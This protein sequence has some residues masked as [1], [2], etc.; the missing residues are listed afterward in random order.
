[1]KLAS[2]RQ[3]WPSYSK[4]L[5]FLGLFLITAGLAI[6]FV[7]GWNLLAGITIA[8]GTIAIA[9]WLF[10]RGNLQSTWALRSTQSNTNALLATLAAL[11]IFGAI[12]FL[13]A[14]YTAKFDLTEK[15]LFTLAPE[16]QQVVKNL[17]QPVKIWIFDRTLSDSD[18]DLLTNYTKINPKFSYQIADPQV[19]FGKAQTFKV[20]SFG[21]VHLE[22]GND[23]RLITTLS[24]ETRLQETDL[25]N[26]IAQLSSTKQSIV[27]F[28]Q[29]HGERP[30]EGEQTGL[31]D[32]IN[33]LKTKNFIAKPLN[34]IREGAIPADA[35]AVA[36]VGPQRS[37][38]D[39]ELSALE[40]YLSQGGR[41][42]ALL[43]PAA[44]GGLGKLLAGWGV[45]LDNR[46]VVDA[47]G[48]GQLAG[49]GPDAP[50]VTRYG[51]H[52]ITQDFKGGISIYPVARSLEISTVSGV[53]ATPI[54]ETDEKSWAESDPK[55]TQLTFTPPQDRQGPLVLGV[56]LE[57]APSP[58]PSPSPAASPSPTGPPSPAAS[59][60]PSPTA[61]PAPSPT[62][63]PSPGV[64]ARPSPAPSPSSAAAKPA[65][66]VA[67]GNSS[68]MADGLF[69]QQLNGD[70]LLNS[71]GWLGD[72]DSNSLSI[73]PREPNNRRIVI[74]P[75]QSSLL[76]LLA[77]VVFPMGGL[78]LAGVMWWQ[79]R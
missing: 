78:T 66:I 37:L 26:A 9:L 47:S 48:T 20:K 22:A 12:N 16:T 74:T 33:G 27:Y 72:R 54:I 3:L 38:L 10:T 28:L 40:T 29:G 77:L 21:E 36:I 50:I 64:T 59:P 62:A 73:R 45:K 6:G 75:Q 30:I 67:I 13:G 65:R 15:Q 1:M 24:P 79:R 51:N 70:V 49:L 32:A 25:T 18:R 34:L 41:L 35:A 19:E 57:R 43:D 56:A 11:L 58:A 44:D 69:G 63:S 7:S 52:P 53:T 17:G 55:A 46:L 39:K 68:F 61:S 8:L 5:I 23:R 14:R 71:V 60:A 42:L 76:L 2:V 4:Y 31:G